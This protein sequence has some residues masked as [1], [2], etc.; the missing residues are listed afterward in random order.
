[1]TTRTLLATLAAVLLLLAI[2]IAALY[3]YRA[4]TPNV[5]FTVPTPT[6]A[7]SA[8]TPAR[9]LPCPTGGATIFGAAG[10]DYRQDAR[11]CIWTAYTT[12]RSAVFTTSGVTVEGARYTWMLTVNSD[13]NIAAA[14]ELVDP[15]T[16]LCRSMEKSPKESDPAKFG[17]RLTGCSPDVPFVNVP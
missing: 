7:P 12:K 13:G 2:V 10:P 15:R 5:S 1:M 8:S 3:A 16:F 17:F 4:Q 9:P 11:D 6:A 14:R